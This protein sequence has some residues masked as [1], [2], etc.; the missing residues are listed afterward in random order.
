[1]FEI[2]C[3]QR[4]GELL[5]QELNEERNPELRL[6]FEVA[7]LHSVSATSRRGTRSLR[8]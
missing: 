5:Q 7:F 2:I 1:M 6:V 3:L 4:N 8:G